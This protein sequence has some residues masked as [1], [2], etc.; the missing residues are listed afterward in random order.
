MMDVSAHL[1]KGPLYPWGKN[2]PLPSEQDAGSA[3]RQVWAFW[4]REKFLALGIEEQTV[5]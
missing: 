5:K 4:R 2:P 1:H 3:P